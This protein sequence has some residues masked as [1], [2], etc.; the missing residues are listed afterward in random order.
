MESIAK[1]VDNKETMSI[2]KR[3][4]E[5]THRINVEK[6]ENGYLVTTCKYGSIP[7]PE[8]EG[9]TKYID[10]TSKTFSKTN[11]LND[12]EEEE[13]SEEEKT[14]ELAKGMGGLFNSLAKSQGM[15]NINK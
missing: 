1:M 4:G 14:K 7:D 13:E 3:E 11:P 5:V 8:N 2:E 12:E 10:E 15:L 6:I 9:K